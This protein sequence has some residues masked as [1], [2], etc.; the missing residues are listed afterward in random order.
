MNGLSLL[1]HISIIHDQ[2][3]S[4]KISYSLTDILFLTVTAVIG[5]AEGWRKSRILAK[6]IWTGYGY[7]VILKMVFPRTI[8]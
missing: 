3:Q 5:G 1:D 6:T 4:W 7:T 2:R 8:R